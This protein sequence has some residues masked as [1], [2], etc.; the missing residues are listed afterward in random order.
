MTFRKA[1]DGKNWAVSN[2]LGREVGNRL[3]CWPEEFRFETNRGFGH[4][5]NNS[6]RVPAKQQ[7]FALT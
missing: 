2:M 4:L 6:S 7:L 1:A 3:H 5:L